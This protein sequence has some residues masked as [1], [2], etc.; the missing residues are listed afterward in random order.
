M[1]IVSFAALAHYFLK[2]HSYRKVCVL[3]DRSTTNSDTRIKGPEQAEMQRS[4]SMRATGSF[5]WKGPS[6]MS[7]LAGHQPQ[8]APREGEAKLK[9]VRG[10]VDASLKAIGDSLWFCMELH[11]CE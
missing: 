1:R 6:F 4:R 2:G 3:K 8:M 11:A 10:C 9:R 5:L 7:R